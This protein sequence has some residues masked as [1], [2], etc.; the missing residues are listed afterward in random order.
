MAQ[1]RGKPDLPLEAGRRLLAHRFGAEHLEGGAAPQQRVLDLVDDAHAAGPQLAQQAVLAQPLHRRR[2]LAQAAQEEHPRHAEHRHQAGERAQRPQDA[3]ERAQGCARLG[4]GHLGRDPEAPTLE[5]PPRAHDLDAAKIPVALDVD[6][7]TATD[8][9]SGHPGERQ[10]RRRHA[11]HV[12][13]PRIANVPIRDFGLVRLERREQPATAVEG[14]APAVGAEAGRADHAAEIAGGVQQHR[15]RTPARPGGVADRRHGQEAEAGR[16]PAVELQAQRARDQGPVAH[17]RAQQLEGLG[18]DAGAERVGR[19]RGGHAARG[20]EQQVA[21][22][23]VLL[24]EG[25]E[26]TREPSGFRSGAQ[27]LRRF[28]GEGRPHE[29]Q[30]GGGELGIA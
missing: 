13:R 23:A 5:P 1:A 12:A 20:V 17:R 19:A 26:L 18:A 27:G 29:G 25:S 16:D 15:E 11:G 24:G 22:G 6:A 3:G 4:L 2:A 21:G 30:G 10:R 28:L 14:V 8:G 9:R 7:A